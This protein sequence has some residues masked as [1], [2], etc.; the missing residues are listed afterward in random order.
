VFRKKWKSKF[1]FLIGN[2]DS[3]MKD[4]I[5]EIRHALI[6]ERLRDIRMLSHR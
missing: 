6:D 5:K 1:L 2:V 3:E 4:L